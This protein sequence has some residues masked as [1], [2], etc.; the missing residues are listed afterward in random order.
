MKQQ[1]GVR[2][3]V[4]LVI[5]MLFLVYASWG[6]VYIGNKLS[7][8]IAG[9]F[10]VC[11]LRNG[12]AGLL[13]LAVCYLRK[14]SW[15]TPSLKDVRNHA[16]IGSMLV[17]M[18]SGFLTLGQTQV[19]S[20]VA[21]VI[22]GS[23]PIVMLVAAWLFAGDEVPTRTQCIGMCTGACAI[24]YLSWSEQSAG[25]GTVL[26]VL[27]LLGAIAGWVSGSLIM[28]TANIAKDMPM[29]ESTGLLLLMGGLESL[30]VASLFGEFSTIQPQ[31]LRPDTI[32]AFSWMVIGGSF[33]AYACYI[34][35][36]VNVNVSL[37]VSYEYV[38]PVIGILL[39]CFIGG[40]KVSADMI[41]ACAVSISSVFLVVR[42]RHSFKSYIRHYL[43]HKS[44][45]SR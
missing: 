6:S 27:I 23:T 38:C 21:A 11:G 35:L 16:L 17:L 41:A 42:H 45:S 30:V 1:F 34:W 3:P 2:P 18:S 24:V 26:G 29:M 31:N 22:M 20:G 33:L 12:L 39:G 37:A 9:P 43:V 25:T 4:H 7:L 19:A 36:L 28:K 5:I 40:E 14:K 15:K 13:T 44:V 8:E 10:L 32:L